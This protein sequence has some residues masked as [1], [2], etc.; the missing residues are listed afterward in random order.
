MSTEA[1]GTRSK[2]SMHRS[3]V[4][5]PRALVA[6]IAFARKRTVLVEVNNSGVS[7]NAVK[8]MMSPKNAPPRRGSH[9]SVT[10]EGP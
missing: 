4:L 10:K 6:L 5:F 8:S 2:W 9:K 1:F 7:G 3:L